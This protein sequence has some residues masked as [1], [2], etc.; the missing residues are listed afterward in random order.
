MTAPPEREVWQRGALPGVPSLLQPV[1]HALLQAEEEINKEM[2]TFP[3]NLLWERLGGVASVG[4]H[5]QHLTG[6][7]DRLFT[8]AQAHPLSEAQLHNLSLEGKENPDIT[9]TILIETFHKQ[10]EKS[11]AQLKATEEATL[12]EARGIGRAQIPTTVIGLYVHAAE[13]TMRHVGQLLVTARIL[14][15]VSS[16]NSVD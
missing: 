9:V 2:R 3:E 6:V 15:S 16:A 1:A 8:Y 11:I 7:L 4:F 14:K 12:L 10:V 13:H 5:L